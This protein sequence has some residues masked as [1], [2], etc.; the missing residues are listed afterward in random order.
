MAV[1]VAQPL[2]KPAGRVLSTLEED[3]SRRWLSPRLSKGRFWGRRRA[4]AYLLIALFTLI[5]YLRTR[6]K[7]MI[8][9]DVIHRKFTLFGVTF[10]PTD[11]VLLALFMVSFILGI[12]FMT[13]VLGRVWCGWACP[14]TVYMEFLFRPIERL[15]MGKSGVGG[16]PNQT[17]A[18][19]RIALKY[20]TYVLVSAYLAHTFL[21][22]FVGVANLRHWVTES[23]ADHPVAFIVMFVTTGLM[24]FNFGFFR[25]Q[26]CLIACPYGRIQSV[27]LDKSSLII[28]YDVNRGEPRGRKARNVALPVLEKTTGDCVDCSMCVQVCPTGIDI[29]DGLQFECIGC[30]QCI[31][32]CDAVMDKLNVPRGLIRYSSQ[33]AMAGQR[34]QFQRPRLFVYVA[35]IFILGGVLVYLLATRASADV[36]V[37][38][39]LGQPFTVTSTGEVEN[40]MRLKIT[41]RVDKKQRFRVSVVDKPGV[42]AAASDDVLTLSSGQMA[43]EPLHVTAPASLFRAGMLDVTLHVVGDAGFSKDYPCKLLGPAVVNL[44]E[45]NE[46][47]HERD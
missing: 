9:L 17:V 47:K 39:G 36:T 18:G 45:T 6:G 1:E 15:F 41:N 29:R 13:A 3:G 33:S 44:K 43:L 32:A 35:M 19:W 40:V 24:L 4:V 46:E 7:P 23:P 21:S 27:L 2:I 42:K 8:F 11:T 10:L 37:L 31:D 5:P 22:Y 26:T 30:A 14:Q 28:S 20:V 25:E 16:K 12:F 38:R 34:E